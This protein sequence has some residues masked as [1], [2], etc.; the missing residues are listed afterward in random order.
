M[1][2]Y[3]GVDWHSWAVGIF[4]IPEDRRVEILVGPAFV[5]IDW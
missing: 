3:C 5:D 1:K 2:F 4:V